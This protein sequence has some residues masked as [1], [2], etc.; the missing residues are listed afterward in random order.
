[1]PAWHGSCKKKGMKPLPPR[2]RPAS[3]AAPSAWLPREIA[4]VLAIKVV[5]LAA[6]WWAFFSPTSGERPLPADASRTF[7]ERQPVSPDPN[8]RSTR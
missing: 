7:L 6:L 2:S 4:V 8:S 1:V 5:A 3:P